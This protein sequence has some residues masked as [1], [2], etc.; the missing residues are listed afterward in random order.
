M[1]KKYFRITNETGI[2][3]RPATTLVNVAME[4]KCDITLSALKHE[5]DFKSIMGVMS[6][7]IYSGTAIEVKCDGED[8]AEAMKAIGDKI[9]SLGLG[10]EV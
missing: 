9:L 1:I 5:V 8:E 6:L 7:G 10:K 2:H 4:F 3:A